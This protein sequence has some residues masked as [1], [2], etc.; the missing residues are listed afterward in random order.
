MRSSPVADAFEADEIERRFGGLGRVTP[1]DDL[2]LGRPDMQSWEMAAIAEQALELLTSYYV[3]LPL[4][5]ALYAVDPQQRL[6]ILA[7]RLSDV[8]RGYL[9][10]LTEDEF[11]EEM[12]SI[13]TSL[14][15][16]H[17]S[18]TLPEPYRSRIAFLPFLLEECDDGD[19][20]VFPLTKTFGAFS[21]PAFAPGAVVTHWNGVPIRRAVD[22]NAERTGGSNRA[23]RRARG[24]ERLTFR[25]MGRLSSPDEHW[26]TITYEIGGERR[27]LRFPWLVVERA[28]GSEGPRAT[29]R[30]FALGL[31]QEGEWIRSVKRLLYAD[32]DKWD[33]GS[34]DDL[35]AYRTVRRPGEDRGY[36]YLRLF[37]FSVPSGRV[38]RFVSTVRRL[39]KAAPADGLIIDIRGNPGGD[40]VAAERL[41]QLISPV[42]IE[43]EALDFIN[44]PGASVLAE[45]LYRARGAA[46]RFNAIRREASS[47]AAPFIP[48]LPYEP[49]ERYNEIGQVYQGPVALIV[50][51]LSYSAADVF[52]AGFQDHDLGTVV[53][54]DP[55]TGGGG[56]NVWP[57]E[58]IR[59][60][61][62]PAMPRALPYDATFDVAV[63]RTTRVGGRAGVTLEDRGVVTDR[64]PTPLTSADALGANEE[65]LATVIGVLAEPPRSYGL[66]A[67]WRGSRRS[68]KLQAANLARVDVYLD[69]RPF[70]SLAEPDGRD[71][72]VP[73]EVGDPAVARFIGYA[74]DEA[75]ARP[76]VTFRWRARRR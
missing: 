23:A 42:E 7:N 31:D 66:R 55:Q 16:L 10:S 56:G 61:G 38:D 2:R 13:F 50:D 28:P 12:A 53:G 73:E 32:H 47:T 40:I 60:F 51:A 67:A 21:D 27:H 58:S 68:F 35:L 19:G 71:V 52:A 48:S 46:R 34:P 22:L 9:D 72:E 20:R 14:R 18:Y 63:R 39:L 30:S 76:V 59:R 4:K 44:T 41:L 17:T 15:D 64:E 57:Y 54:T 43:P 5:R 26:V 3:H 70:G 49:V 74:T 1:L 33:A 11:H 37:S 36:G 62:D 65:L 69:G 8:E 25:W 6:R 29:Q 45:N 24:V 75:G